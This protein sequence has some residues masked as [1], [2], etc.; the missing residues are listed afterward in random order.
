MD[1]IRAQL[2]QVQVRSLVIRGWNIGILV[3]GSVCLLMLVISWAIE[4]NAEGLKRRHAGSIIALI[5]T[6]ATLILSIVTLYVE[7]NKLWLYGLQLAAVLSLMLTAIASGMNAIVIDVCAAGQAAT[8]VPCGAHYFEFFVSFV[9]CVCL[10]S[11][12]GTTQQKVIVL[13]DRGVLTGLGSRMQ[14]IEG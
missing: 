6:I 14:K 11:I 9:I 5:F 1:Q 4:A 2:E 7:P 13:V 12:Y 8:V 10:A 3:T